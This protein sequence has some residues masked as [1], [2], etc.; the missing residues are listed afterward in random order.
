MGARANPIKLLKVMECERDGG[1]F[2]D[3]RADMA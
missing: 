2:D 1:G 3:D